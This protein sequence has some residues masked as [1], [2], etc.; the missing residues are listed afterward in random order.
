MS[1]LIDGKWST[2]EWHPY[3]TDDEH[4]RFQ[5]LPATFRDWITLDGAPGP[6]GDAGLKAEPGRYHLYVALVCPWASRTLMVRKLK[7]LEDIISVSIV[8]PFVTDQSWKFGDFPGAI[9]DTVNNATYLHEI[10]TKS[11]PHF[12]GRV[13]VPVLWDK[14]QGVIVNN[15]SADIVRMLN[16]AFDA[17][18]DESM[19]LYPEDLRAHIDA[20]N[21]EIYDSFNN[22]VYRAGFA[23]SQEAYDDAVSAVFAALEMLEDRLECQSY[24]MGEQLTESDIRAF[25]TLIRFDAAYH[26]LFK[27]NIKRI[28]DYPDLTAYLGRI[29][30]IPGIRETV[31]MDHIKRGYYSV[32]ALNP[33]GIVPMGPFSNNA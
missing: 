22:G 25:V 31:N 10:Y 19:D 20:L 7:K 23:R 15:E 6:A 1:M 4:G 2:E 17:F 28:A 29:I 11:D 33:T 5:R 21:D 32:K 3:Q 30:D 26:G 12:T 18:G 8:E 14:H 16:S 27:C 13:T 9:A 24:L